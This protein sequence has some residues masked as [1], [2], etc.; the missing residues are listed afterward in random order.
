MSCPEELTII[1]SGTGYL[2]IQE[3][4]LKSKRKTTDLCR[5]ARF[6][7][8]GSYF[9]DDDWR[10]IVRVRPLCGDAEGLPDSKTT[11]VRDGRYEHN[12]FNKVQQLLV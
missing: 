11:P 7:T 6:G 2:K 4:F 1:S 12:G 5:L 9:F 8:V 3:K 10:K